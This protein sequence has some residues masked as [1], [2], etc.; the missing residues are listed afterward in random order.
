MKKHELERFLQQFEILRGIQVVY[1][2]GLSSVIAPQIV[3][4]TGLVNIHGEPHM[5]ES[6]INLNDFKTHDDVMR[7]AKAILTAFD[8]AEATNG[9]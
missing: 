8:K 1:P 7:L 5:F 4:L 2:E 6:E 3:L 9:S